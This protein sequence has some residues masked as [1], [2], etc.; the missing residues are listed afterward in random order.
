[1]ECRPPSRHRR[2]LSG[3]GPAQRRRRL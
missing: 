1:V 2:R 3:A